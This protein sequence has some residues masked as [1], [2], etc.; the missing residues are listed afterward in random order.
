MALQ[1]W[2]MVRK[3]GYVFPIYIGDEHPHRDVYLEKESN[4]FFLVS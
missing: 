2:Q 4:P 3:K 1:D